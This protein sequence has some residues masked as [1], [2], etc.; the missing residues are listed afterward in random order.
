MLLLLPCMGETAPHG[1]H[2]ESDSKSA[3]LLWQ[4]SP[5]SHTVLA[6]QKAG[7]LWDSPKLLP[8]RHLG[9]HRV[10]GAGNAWLSVLWCSASN[11]I[12]SKVCFQTL[13]DLIMLLKSSGV[14]NRGKMWGS[15][16]R[17]EEQ[18]RG[19]YEGVWWKY[20]PQSTKTEHPFQKWMLSSY[21]CW[22]NCVF[23]TLGSLGT[24]SCHLPFLPCFPVPLQSGVRHLQFSSYTWLLLI[25][26][27]YYNV[28]KGCRSFLKPPSNI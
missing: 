22:D 27:S 4:L 26:Q 16:F 23:P 25:V 8:L 5:I 6:A 12:G 18:L 2:T 9:E 1:V 13:C 15:I 24:S 7:C 17:S 20:L 3:M 14:L 19:G 28:Y 21:F 11:K 10:V